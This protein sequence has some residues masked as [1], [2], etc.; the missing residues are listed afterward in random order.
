MVNNKVNKP[1][2]I[3]LPKSSEVKIKADSQKNRPLCSSIEVN[4]HC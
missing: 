2:R 3:K 4:F 1:K